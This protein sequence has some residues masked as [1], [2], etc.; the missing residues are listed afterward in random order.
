MHYLKN[1]KQLWWLRTIAIFG[2][3]AAIFSVSTIFT[4]P[5]PLAPLWLI[6][7]AMV[8]INMLTFLRLR[9]QVTIT[10][11]EFFAQLLLDILALFGLLYFSGG[12][13]NPFTSLFILQVVIAAATLS[14]IYTW[15][16]A[17]ITIALYTLL[18]FWNVDVPAMHHHHDGAS[19]NL[20]I[21]GMWVSFVVLALL[22]AGFVVR[23]NSTLRKQDQLLADAEQIAAL[24]TLATS[25]AHELGTPLSIMAVLAGDYP[26]EQ[27]MLLKQQLQ[28]C[29]HIIAQ[30]TLSASVMRAESGTL[31][32]LDEFLTHL[33]REW[34]EL[35]PTTRCD[36]HA[37]ADS[38]PVTIIAEHS[39]GQAIMNL[40]SNAA[41]ASPETIALRAYW[42]R[43]ALTLEISDRGTGF[44]ASILATIGQ[45]GTTTKPEGMGMG[46]YLTKTILQRLGGTLQ[47]RNQENGGAVAIIYLPL[48]KLQ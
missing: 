36:Y 9:Q 27:G 7:G 24:G 2:Q 31:M 11:R 41:D 48:Q 20:H 4:L 21:H 30:I 35:R 40:L 17:L 25:A 6:I 15:L 39:L 10:E 38:P 8:I 45:L 42:S 14:P 12:A 29:K 3:S 33:L 37:S 28:R 47:L 22:V 32:P 44:P 34:Q 19:F 23:M 18:M 5:L 43:T 26:G 13:S 16:S 46:L 1:L